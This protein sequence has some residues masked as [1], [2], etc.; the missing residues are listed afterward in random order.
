MKIEKTCIR[1]NKIFFVYPSSKAKFCSRNCYMSSIAGKNN[2]FYGRHHSERTK[3]Y[4]SEANKG[5]PG[6]WTGKK[7]PSPSK[8]ARENMSKAAK[9][10]PKP[11]L[12]DKELSKE[13]K[14]KISKAN[15]GKKCSK[16]AI[17]KTRLF[18]LGRKRSKVT[19]ENLR[20]SHLGKP[21]Y[22]TGKKRLSMT[23][24]KNYNWKGG[25]Y[26]IVDKIRHSPEIKLWRKK[27]FKRDNYT[28][29]KT[30]IK[31]G[32]LCSHHIKN[33]SEYPE[34]RFETSNGITLSQKMH[35]EFHK[36]YG[37]KNNTKEQLIE[38]LN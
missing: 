33:F 28:C 14:E 21:G 18:H 10:K 27:V 11:W 30:N 29:Q 19:K 6:Y 3:R 20:L 5:N 36:I 2:P 8:K 23:G 13:H 4:I 31:G 37:W 9:G 38:F 17:E 12:K 34:L 16:E 15:L 26:P 24:S 35:K 7:R 25:I 22:W 32:E 1:C